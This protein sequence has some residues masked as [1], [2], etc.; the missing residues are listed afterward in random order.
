MIIL[1]LFKVLS[2]KFCHN[3]HNHHPIKV[4]NG[5]VLNKAAS[6]DH[7]SIFEFIAERKEYA[8]NEDDIKSPPMWKRI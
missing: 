4:E 6:Q 2:D 1:N 3:N 7:L 5:L 8:E